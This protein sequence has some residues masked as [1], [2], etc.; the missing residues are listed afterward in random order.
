DKARE[1][2]VRHGAVGDHGAIEQQRLDLVGAPS[3]MK[4][5]AVQG[6]ERTRVRGAGFGKDR[7]GPRPAKDRHHR[8]GNR[9]AS[10]GSAAAAR[11]VTGSGGVSGSGAAAP[12]RA[13]QSTSG[14]GFICTMA[15]AGAAAGQAAA[16]M[17]AAEPTT[18]AGSAA[19][20]RAASPMLTMR[21]ATRV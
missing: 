11:R 10:C 6:G 4:R 9:A 2:G 20:E 15:G 21:G 12:R 18:R 1:I 8:L 13:T 17:L 7:F 3:A 5:G 19:A 14:A 16:S